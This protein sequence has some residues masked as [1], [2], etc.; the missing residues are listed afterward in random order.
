M[1]LNLTCIGELIILG[2][3]V[4]PKQMIDNKKQHSRLDIDYI[5]KAWISINEIFTYILPTSSENN[6]FPITHE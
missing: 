3:I 1:I 5:T 4:A 2:S 6:G